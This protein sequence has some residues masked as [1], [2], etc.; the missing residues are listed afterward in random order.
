[1]CMD[2][3]VVIAGAVR[4]PIG[5]VG[6]ALASLQAVDLGERAV[7]ALLAQAGLDPAEV[8][9]TTMGWV[10]QDPRS[11]NIAKIIAERAG[12]PE[13]SPG[14]TVHENCASGGAAIHDVARRILL[15]EIDLG[16]AGGAESMSNVPRY[17]FQ[18]R[19]KGQLYGDMKLEDGLMGALLER[20]LR[21]GPELMGLMTERIVT[22]YGLRREDL[23][24]V[25]FDSHRNAHRAWEEGAFEGYVVPVE[26]PRRRKEPLVVTRDEGPREL[27]MEYF[28]SARPYFQPDGGTITSQNSSSINDAAAAVILTTPE[29]AQA[30]GLEVLAELVAFK[31]VGVERAYMGEGAFEVILPLLERAGLPLAEVDLFEINE[32]FAA[33]VAAALVKLPGLERARVNPWGSG[34]SLGHPVG[35]TGARQVVDMV[36]QLRRRGQR[37][38]VTTRCVGGGIGSG[39]LIR[40]FG[41]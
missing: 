12:V 7:R 3:K 1:M 16:I 34:I 37:F 26:I 21:T 20:E 23:D 24:R 10:A 14:T 41:A 11:T 38:G 4:T 9:Y 36:H 8:Q 6:G 22:R 33:V 17:L 39:E 15:G 18:G 35:C 13:T 27:P 32:A 19:T 5:A 25:A 31:N 40:A 29:K 30:L 2:R 28:S